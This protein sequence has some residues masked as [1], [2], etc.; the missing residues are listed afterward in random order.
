MHEAEA[1][2]A[3][4]SKRNPRISNGAARRAIRARWKAIGD[5][6][7]LCG[8]PIDYSLGMIVDERTGKKRPHPMS[9]VVDEIIPVS[10]Y[11]E[12]GFESPEQAAITW[13]N[14]Q[15][16]HYICNARK[17][18]SITQADTSRKNGVGGMRHS[19]MS[20]QLPQPF[21]EW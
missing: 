3:V 6:C 7:H 5:P 8:K 4:M 9:F 19:S 1:W 20:K 11:R 14:T 17:G 18:N 16:A 15:P 21:D 13:G 2:R 10:R 12:G